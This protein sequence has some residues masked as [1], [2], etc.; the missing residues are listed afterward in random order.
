MSGFLAPADGVYVGTVVIHPIRVPIGPS[1]KADSDLMI[2]DII[3]GSDAHQLRHPLVYAL[4][5]HAPLETAR[6]PLLECSDGSCRRFSFLEV[7]IPGKE[8]RVWII[9]KTE[10]FGAM[11]L[12]LPLYVLVFSLQVYF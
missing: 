8:F 2:T 7:A 1:V 3:D 10:G 11:S 4:D 9:Y 5:P 12:I 6:G